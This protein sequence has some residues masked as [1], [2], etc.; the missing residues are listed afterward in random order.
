MY[1][2]QKQLKTVAAVAMLSA[3]LAGA[4]LWGQEAAKP[5]GQEP[6]K[7]AAPAKKLAE[8]EYDLYNAALVDLGKND[9]T[10]G[11][12]DLDA[13]KQKFPSSDY[14]PERQAQYVR[15][16]AGSKQPDKAM[17]I[18]S[19]L[20]KGKADDVQKGSIDDLFPDPKSGPRVVLQVLVTAVQA[21]Q[22]IP[23]PTADQ[24]ATAQKAAE[25]LL[26]YNRK[27]EGYSDDQWKQ[28]HA[29]VDP[30]ARQAQFFLVMAPGVD[31]LQKKDYENAEALFRKALAQYPD[32]AAVAADLAAAI[33]GE[34]I[35]K[36]HPEKFPEALF[37]YARASSMDPKTS[38]VTKEWQDNVAKSLTDYYTKYHGSDEGLADLKAAAAKSPNPPEGFAIKTGAELE[39]EKHD[40]F[41]S[42]HPDLARWLEV[43]QALTTGGESYFKDN[44]ADA[45]MPLFRGKVLE[46]KPACNSRELVVALSDDTTPEVTLKLDTPLRGKP[47]P[48][49]VTFEGAV[50]KTF[51]ASPFMLTMNMDPTK[52]QGLEKGACGATPPP[53][54]KK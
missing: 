50:A 28:L 17:D 8:G 33:V 54:K 2:F 49:E 21:I 4:P 15:A 31:A 48:G 27:A 9:F 30:M 11:L 18:A 41:V 39:K 43:K 10:K 23:N 6:A 1:I 47:V 24:A 13:W 32:N 35:D 5:A 14:S 36:K 42:T 19:D 20:L 52:I 51:T 22:Q 7:P 16:Y 37:Y 44:M 12:A 34:Y 29:Q 38:G 3:A 46:G 25:L 53:A 45:A 40:A 26:Q